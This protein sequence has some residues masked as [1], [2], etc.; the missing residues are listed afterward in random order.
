MRSKDWLVQDRFLELRSRWMTLI[1]EHL[2]DDQGQTLEYWRIEKAD[3]LIVL[4]IQCDRIVLPPPSYRPGMGQAS[5]DFPGGRVP[6][7][8]SRE[9]RE[10]TAIAI[11]KRELAVDAAEIIQL[12]PLNT[13]G[14]P[15][16]S[17]FS[18][19][20][21]YGYVANLASAANVL[22]G[23]DFKAYPV[24]ATGI[25]QLRQALICL[26]CRAVLLEWW[27]SQQVCFE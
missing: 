13:E 8:S 2:Q 14:W 9:Q 22:S 26:Q 20:K 19:Q 6:E 18:N 11:L 23:K 5:L 12:R 3:S 15:V 24:N 17:S 10:Q 7:G 21:L 16:N 4:P 1:G 25:Q 27:C